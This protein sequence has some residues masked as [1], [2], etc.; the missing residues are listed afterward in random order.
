M[1]GPFASTVLSD[2]SVARIIEAGREI[3]SN[4][5][6][7]V[8]NGALLSLLA[9]HG[10]IID[11]AEQRARF[12]RKMIDALLK[13]SSDSYDAVDG[14]EA[15][16]LLPWGD[17]ASYSHGVECTAG[18]Y[19]TGCLY[20]D[21]EVKPHTLAST[22]EMTRLADALEHI[23]RIGAMGVP[24]DVRAEVSP[25]YQRLVA[26]KN[27]ERKLSN[28]GEVRSPELC[29]DI[30]EMG[31]IVAADKKASLR[32]YAFAEVELVSPLRFARQEAVI[33]ERF[34][35]S[36]LLCGVG[37]MHSA[38]G[39]APV[40]LAGVLAL[41]VAENL[42][43]NLLY[44]YCYGFR[45]LWFQTNSSVMDMRRGMFAFGRPERGLLITAT[46]QV[47][48][49]LHAGL[50][51]CAIYPDAK[52]PGCEAGMQSS[53]NVIPVILAGTLGCGCFGLLS[54]GD[55]QL[56]DPA[57]SRQRALRRGEALRARHR[58]G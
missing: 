15:S 32:R 3:L 13:G 29:D 18:G 27:A 1:N 22:A 7:R 26:W 51:A 38:G 57:Y 48:R 52:T 41:N 44:R 40:S 25:L 56:P 53:F 12:G 14:V 58:G 33:F 28:C 4:T 16:H 49:R 34:W 19:P 2:E 23:D 24:S 6:C 30:V 45:K 21:G 54:G 43:I 31:R 5:G 42:L 9:E 37:F 17:R 47:A 39:S 20:P 55:V 36:G 10:A 50:W 8:E 35:K 46:G 11:K